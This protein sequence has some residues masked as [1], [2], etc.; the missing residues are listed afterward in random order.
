MSKFEIS[1]FM[2]KS[3]LENQN[4]IINLRLEIL[5]SNLYSTN[6]EIEVG[7]LKKFAKMKN[8]IVV[9]LKESDK[10]VAILN[11]LP[12]IYEEDN[13][14]SSWRETDFDVS[15]I[16]YFKEIIILPK[17]DRIDLRQEI[18]HTAQD[19]I[20]GFNQYHFFITSTG[21]NRDN[22]PI[23]EEF[24]TQNSY[25]KLDIKSNSRY[26]IENKN[27]NNKLHFWIKKI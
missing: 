16:Y 26:K 7:Y 12:L 22:I 11:A 19:W 4:D 14:L 27:I 21:I 1:L 23:I 20:L 2:G 6:S 8:S 3:I 10:I 13:I 24:Y 15:F 9:I 17:Y 5:T 18:L 25:D